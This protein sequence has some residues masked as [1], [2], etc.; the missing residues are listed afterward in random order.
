[1]PNVDVAAERVVRIERERMLERE[2]YVSIQQ[3]AKLLGTKYSIVYA[4]IQRGELTAERVRRTRY[5]RLASIQM[6]LQER[7]R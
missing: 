3:A 2:G 5:V 1:M 7:A 4:M 6:R